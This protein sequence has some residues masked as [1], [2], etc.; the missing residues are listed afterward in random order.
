MILLIQLRANMSRSQRSIIGGRWVFVQISVLASKVVVVD[1][2]CFYM[3]RIFQYVCRRPLNIRKRD[4]TKWPINR[5]REHRMVLRHLSSRGTR[6]GSRS[7]PFGFR[8]VW[9]IIVTNHTVI[10]S[11]AAQIFFFVQ[12]PKDKRMHKTKLETLALQVPYL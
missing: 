6:R 2:I 8:P 12:G 5:L 7:I 1:T 11:T 10:T 9:D 4:T 3:R